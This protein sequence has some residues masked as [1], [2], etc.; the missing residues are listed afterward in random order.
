MSRPFASP[1]SLP[2]F[3]QMAATRNAE[4]SE[5]AHLP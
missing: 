2:K 4:R 1:E 5:G 3:V